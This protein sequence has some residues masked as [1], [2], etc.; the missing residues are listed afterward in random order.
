LLFWTW[1]RRDGL[2]IWQAPAEV[3]TGPS[4]A[5]HLAWWLGALAV[6]YVG[7]RAGLDL[8]LPARVRG[9]VLA[10]SQFRYRGRSPWYEIVIDDGRGGRTRPW[11]ASEGLGAVLEPH[12]I[13][14]LR[15]ERW[16]RR[17]RSRTTSGPR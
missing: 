11:L 9:I 5:S 10:R 1:P 8:V 12:S 14:E 3:L 4:A 7:L 17:L 2:R 15:G 6:A 16:S 13:V